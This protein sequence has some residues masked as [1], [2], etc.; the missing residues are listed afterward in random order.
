M[1]TIKCDLCNGTEFVKQDDM[2]VCQG[3]GTKYS[4]EEAR[5]LMS[6]DA[7]STTVKA[8]NT[9]VK[10][11]LLNAKNTYEQSNYAEAYRLY[12]EVLNIEPDNPTALLY[13][14]A[15]SAWQSSVAN[16]K[17]GEAATSAITAISYAKDKFNE[18]EFVGF[19]G[20]LCKTMAVLSFS[21][22]NLADNYV[23]SCQQKIPAY[24][25]TGAVIKSN[26]MG[27]VKNTATQKKLSVLLD[28]FKV[29]DAICNNIIPGYNYNDEFCS[30][31]FMF[32]NQ[33][34]KSPVDNSLSFGIAKIENVLAMLEVVNITSDREESENL[35]KVF[36]TKLL[37]SS[38]LKKIENWWKVQK[39]AE[40]YN[41]SQPV[42]TVSASGS[43]SSSG[44]G[45]CYVA[46]AVYGSYDCPEVWTLR[47]FR[48]DTLAETWYGRAFVK[49]YYAISPTIVKWFGDTEWFKKMW[50]STLDRMVAGLQAKGVE[51]TPYDD[52]KW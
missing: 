10:N 2:F 30:S 23:A 37:Q 7:V 45:C 20:E 49:T 47:R 21:L 26:T 1:G 24:S 32:L 4:P 43:T 48:D 38:D 34:G 22:Y 41:L 35:Q 28:G 16:M 9:E 51:S 5:K 11:R 8:E 15:S 46:T 36:V 39:W 17:F 27:D 42:G 40:K 13:R 29:L 14:G 18:E 44:G 3:C 52:K 6:D 19:L 31:L 50:R 25:V 33:V 12:S